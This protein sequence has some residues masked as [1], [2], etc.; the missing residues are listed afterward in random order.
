MKTVGMYTSSMSIKV[1]PR[2]WFL[3]A[4]FM[5]YTSTVSLPWIQ[6]ACITNIISRYYNVSG[7]LVESTSV[8]I[9]AARAF[10][11]V[12]SLFFIDKLVS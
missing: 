12:P 3:L 1:Y 10:L 7:I 9:M 4:L 2:R 5:L 8:M 11:L 6:F